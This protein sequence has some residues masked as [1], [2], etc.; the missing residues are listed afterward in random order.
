MGD[1]LF[2]NFDALW[3]IFLNILKDPDAGEIYL[4]VDALDE[5]ESSSRQILLTVLANTFVPRQKEMVR[6]FVTS[7]LEPDI[8]EALITYRQGTSTSWL[9]K[10]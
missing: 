1:Q 9:R 10:C 2:G 3:R 5:C 7:R 6:F 8:Q 4:L